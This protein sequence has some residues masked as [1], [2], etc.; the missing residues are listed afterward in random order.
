MQVEWDP[1]DFPFDGWNLIFR[2]MVNAGRRCDGHS[3]FYYIV[4]PVVATLRFLLFEIHSI[5]LP[6]QVDAIT[7]DTGISLNI[8]VLY[9]KHLQSKWTGSA[10]SHTVIKH[11]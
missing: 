7:I 10:E 1:I 3:R 9:G 5:A 4:T 8:S 6:P 11:H 2:N